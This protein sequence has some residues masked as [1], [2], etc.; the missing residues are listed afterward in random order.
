MAK[1]NKVIDT[2]LLKLMKRNFVHEV[3]RDPHNKVT[4]IVRNDEGDVVATLPFDG[5]VYSRMKYGDPEA[6]N[7]AASEIF[8]LI[9]SNPKIFTI[10]KENKIVFTNE[11]REVPTASY[12]IMMSLVHKFL[13]PYLVENNLQTAETVRSERSGEIASDDY[14]TLTT[15]QRQDRV[16]QRGGFFSDEN[17]KKLVGKKVVLF[18][19]LVITG[20]YET[21]QT[22]L[23]LASGVREEDIV[24]IYWIQI[25]PE[26]GKDPLFEKEL[27]QSAVN[28]LSDLFGIFTLPGV[29]PSER[30]I[31]YVLSITDDNGNLLLEKQNE[32]FNLAQ[33]LVTG[34]GDPIKAANGKSTLKKLYETSLTPD[35]FGQMER[36]KAG[37]RLIENVL[38]ENYMI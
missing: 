19:D 11:A 16:R 17:L 27:N 33:R 3:G 30:I 2:E 24:P 5:K 32:L 22:R 23:L 10:F 38:R 14:A 25:N 13:N 1:P 37:Y 7:L 8:K 18:D 28:S 21:N 34:N 20:T 35:G 4:K 12:C 31:K 36:F 6:I 26:T 29:Q 9:T 15:D